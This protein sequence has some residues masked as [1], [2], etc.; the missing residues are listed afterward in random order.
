MSNPDSVGIAAPNTR[1]RLS[2]LQCRAAVGLERGDRERGVDQQVAE[3]DDG[4]VEADPHAHG[5]E[6]RVADEVTHEQ[7]RH[8]EP[9]RED[10]VVDRQRGGEPGHV[11]QLHAALHVQVGHRD[12]GDHHDEAVLGPEDLPPDDGAEQALPEPEV[13]AACGCSSDS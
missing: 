1:I 7:V 10:R 9:D 8:R 4:L 5:R 11:P 6:E 13:R 3:A 2:E 12:R